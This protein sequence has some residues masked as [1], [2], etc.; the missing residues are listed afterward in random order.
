MCV[1]V[2]DAGAT[3]HPPN[4]GSDNSI[5]PTSSYWDIFE[6]IVTNKGAKMLRRLDTGE[7]IPISG[8]VRF[9]R[10]FIE[11]YDLIFSILLFLDSQTKL[12]PLGR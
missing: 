11:I 2:M 1:V 5:S 3:Q 6:L 4:V 8:K 10:S 12:N 7:A 9:F